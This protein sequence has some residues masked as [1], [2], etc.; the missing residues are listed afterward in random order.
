LSQ[1]NVENRAAAVCRCQAPSVPLCGFCEDD[2]YCPQCG[3]EITSVFCDAACA[4]DG[5]IWIYPNDKGDFEFSLSLR[6]RGRDRDARETCPELDLSQSRLRVSNWFERELEQLG[7]RADGRAM[8]YRLKP[9]PAYLNR[10][11]GWHNILPLAGVAADL[12][13]SGQFQ[14]TT[15]ALRVCRSPEF[16]ILFSGNDV[17]LDA[18][19]TGATSWEVFRSDKL[20]LDVEFR[21]NFSPV[22]FQGYGP[23]EGPIDV[24]PIGS[25]AAYLVDECPPELELG[26]PQHA[27]QDVAW[28]TRLALDATDWEVGDKR[29]LAFCLRGPFGV[30][31]IVH[32]FHRVAVPDLRYSVQPINIPVLHY[33]DVLRAR[34]H[35]GS[36]AD[37]TIENVGEAAGRSNPPRIE[38]E[39]PPVDESMLV[40]TWAKPDFNGGFS[41]GDQAELDLVIDAGRVPEGELADRELRARIVLAMDDPQRQWTLPVVIRRVVSRP[42][43]QRRVAIDFGNT[44]TYVAV[45][46][47]DD[48]DQVAAVLTDGDPEQFASAMYF[49]D[50]SDPEHPEYIVGPEA[51][52]LGRAC[53]TA[54][55]SMLK[56]WIGER[57]ADG[58][59][60]K[61][62]VWDE[63]GRDATYDIPTLVR[64]FFRGVIGRCE[65]LLHEKVA[66]I[67]VSLPTNSS[68]RRNAA[69]RAILDELAVRMRAETPSRQ[70]ECAERDID[71][72]TAVT[73]AFVLDP[74]NLKK[75]IKNRLATGRRSLVVASVD[76]GGGTVDT[77]L[78]RVHFDCNLDH[79]EFAR[80]GSEYLGLGGDSQFGGDNVTAAILEML[81]ERLRRILQNA[82]ESTPAGV[83]EL[84]LAMPGEGQSR[85]ARGNFDVLWNAAELIKFHLCTPEGDSGCPA[86]PATAEAVAA[87]EGRRVLREQ[88]NVALHE[89]TARYATAG[90]GCKEQ[91]LLQD[92]ALRERL[93]QAIDNGE[94]LCTLDEA[95]RHTIQKDLQGQSGYTVY[96][97]LER[98][99]VELAGFA[100]RHSTDVDFVV[101]A[102]AG[103]RLPLVQQLLA[104]HLP[105]VD[106]YVDVKRAKSK[107]ACGL[108]RYFELHEKAPDHVQGLR[109]ASQYTPWPIGLREPGTRAFKEVVPVCSPVDDPQPWYEFPEGLR[110]QDVWN[111]NQARRIEL[112]CRWG[113]NRVE[114]LGTFDLRQPG[115]LAAQPASA[116]PQA[117][118]EVTPQLPDEMPQSNTVA[119]RFAGGLEAVDL[120]VCIDGRTFGFW[121]MSPAL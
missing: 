65:N 117:V 110:V 100:R 18:A 77:A 87:S 4:D 54:M 50:V 17:L 118:E 23:G 90:S 108:V 55:V 45:W 101:L 31:R 74:E 107:V 26:P 32:T 24:T 11:T 106:V 21:S 72:A 33:G 96:E 3:S 36:L 9:R 114:L 28:K 109:F 112:Y 51:V 62:Y 111:S 12:Q 116:S 8:R 56:R 16:S 92:P 30:Q 27:D 1:A 41:P 60:P 94:L 115:D 52:R 64:L 93:Q 78:I 7:P 46:S 105:G 47:Q 15:F 29:E 91:P 86:S 103:S 119:I 19:E 70:L 80:F 121:R 37:V 48:A 44:N 104:T 6:C 66:R 49:R 95:C 67:G 83:P 58:S 14:S 53:P 89:L 34:R 22:Y 102:G 69:F 99:I 25:F 82:G 71:E 68:P 79:V 38:W 84:R 76:V 85:D 20:L 57:E 59:C 98:C 10:G 113:Q 73:M 75:E 35:G 42:V 97:R 43:C 81:S 39:T 40:A 63:N 120:N 2:L 88:L 61:R 5:V 13:A